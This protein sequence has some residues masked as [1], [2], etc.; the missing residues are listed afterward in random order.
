MKTM[1]ATAAGS[2]GGLGQFQ[3]SKPQYIPVPI[4]Q[5]EAKESKPDVVEEL[6]KK[7]VY[8]KSDGQVFW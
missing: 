8:A 1:G 2:T 6:M 3:Q 5:S 7:N 4:P